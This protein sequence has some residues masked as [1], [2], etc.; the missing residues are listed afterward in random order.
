MQRKQKKNILDF[1]QELMGDLKNSYSKT[2]KR[3]TTNET[4]EYLFMFFDILIHGGTKKKKRKKIKNIKM[5]GTNE[6]LFKSKKQR[7]RATIYVNNYSRI[8]REYIKGGV[9]YGAGTGDVVSMDEA[10]ARAGEHWH[11]THPKI[12]M[13]VLEDKCKSHTF[14]A[15]LILMGN[16]EKNAERQVG[17]LVAMADAAAVQKNPD[18]GAVVALRDKIKNITH[19]KVWAGNWLKVVPDKIEA[20]AI[21]SFDK[22]DLLSSNLKTIMK[23][24]TAEAYAP[25]IDEVHSASKEA[26]VNLGKSGEELLMG[27]VG[28]IG[29]EVADTATALVGGLFPIEPVVSEINAIMLCDPGKC[30]VLTELLWPS[31]IKREVREHADVGKIITDNELKIDLFLSTLSSE[32]CEGCGGPAISKPEKDVNRSLKKIV[33]IVGESLVSTLYKIFTAKKK[34]TAAVADVTN[35]SGAA[36]T[37]AATAATAVTPTNP[38]VVHRT[39]T[40]PLVI[41][42]LI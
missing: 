34:I 14:H 18:L 31:E 26:L 10:K 40:R 28:S 42:N 39:A 25:L 32:A 15:A 36:G 29:V 13:P 3:L 24:A 8:L 33:N 6:F 2:D 30:I 23:N 16:L 4:N 7:E 5:L 19:S 35:A 22:S 11:K 20:A 41:K 38:R 27:E 1:Q 9:L 37:K 21:H 12:D 17:D